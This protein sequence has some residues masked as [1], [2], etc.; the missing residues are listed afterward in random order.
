MVED[1]S[2]ALSLDFAGFLAQH[3]AIQLM[4]N[5]YFQADSY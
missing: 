4:Q 5:L 1:I 3:T 2:C